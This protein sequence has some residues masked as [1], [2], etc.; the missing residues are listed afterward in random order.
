[1]KLYL[2]I[3]ILAFSIGIGSHFGIEKLR[4]YRNKIYIQGQHVGWKNAAIQWNKWIKEQ[5]GIVKVR[6]A[7][8]KMSYLS[9]NTCV[10]LNP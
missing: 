3:V 10:N 7:L 5:G 9:G 1:M 8:L 2:S 4:D 6:Q